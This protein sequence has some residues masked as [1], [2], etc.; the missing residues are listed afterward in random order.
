MDFEFDVLIVEKCSSSSNYRRWHCA[1]DIN[2]M[3]KE[4]D[5]E[6]EMSTLE[7]IGCFM[8]FAIGGVWF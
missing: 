1:E 7:F 5:E 6:E 8:T 3:N 2:W 4:V